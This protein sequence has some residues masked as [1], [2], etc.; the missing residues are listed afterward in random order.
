M[1]HHFRIMRAAALLVISAFILSCTSPKPPEGK[2]LIEFWDFPRLP[3]IKEWQE[4]LVADYN[5]DHPDVFVKLTR[6]SWAKG[7]ERLDIAAFSGRPPDVAGG[8]FKVKYVESGLLAPLDKYLDEETEPSS[9]ESFRFDIY[10]GDLRNVQWRGKAYA[11]PWYREGFVLILNRDLFEERGVPLPKG[12]AWSWEEFLASMHKLTFDRDGD[13][14]IDVYG[15]G[16][17]TGKEK[18]EAYPFLFGEGM[19]ILSEDGRRCIIDSP[20]TRRGIARLLQMEYDEKV[21][22]PGAGGIQ[23]DTTWTMF[24]GPQRQLAVTSQGLWAVQ[25]VKDQNKKREESIAE[26]KDQGALPPPL[27]VSIALFP[28]MPGQ[29]QRMASY[30]V[31]SLMVFN[32][33][34]DPK[35]TEAAARF[36]R[37]LTLEAGQ[38]INKEAGLFPV[39][40]AYGNL[41]DGDPDFAVIAPYTI[42]SI[43]PPIHPAWQQLDQVIGEQL[44]LILLKETS[45]DS[46]VEKMQKRCQIVLDDYWASAD[47]ENHH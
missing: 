22:L 14:K 33:P 26:G 45:L 37:H 23:D 8:V 7:S 1:R 16:F 25:S 9:D 20:E 10:P 44:Q 43:T 15:I 36:A 41:Y 42:E 29:P 32:R 27:R 2:V 21:S 39:R 6:L 38:A 11:F 24:T 5:R 13:G 40:K 47:A 12:G 3:E 28:R 46:G 4:K 17:N 19:Q 18:W 30:G 35:R 34:S 31:G